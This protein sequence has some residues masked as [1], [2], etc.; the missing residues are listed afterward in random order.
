MTATR[1]RTARIT[2]SKVKKLR[3]L[4][5]RRA[6]SASLKVS[7]KATRLARKPRFATAQDCSRSDAGAPPELLRLSKAVTPKAGLRGTA[8]INQYEHRSPFVSRKCE[9]YAHLDAA[10]RICFAYRI[11]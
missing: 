2:P 6:S 1:V 5:A 8:D 4:W 7:E 10:E 11:F 9:G 3:S